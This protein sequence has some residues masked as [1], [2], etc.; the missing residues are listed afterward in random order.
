[1]KPRTLLTTAALIAAALFILDVPAAN[2]G[3]QTWN[4]SG[5]NWNNAANWDASDGASEAAVPTSADLAVLPTNSSTPYTVYMDAN[6]GQCISLNI[7]VDATLSI[8]D[9]K[10]LEVYGDNVTSYVDG[11]ILL[12]YDVS[13][14]DFKGTHIV[15]YTGTRGT[16][17]GDHNDAQITIAE[18]EM[19]TSQVNITGS[20]A[21]TGAGNFTNAWLVGADNASETLSLEIT[22]TLDDTAGERWQA[23]GGTLDFTAAIGTLGPLEGDLVISSGVI[24][25]NKALITTGALE[26]TDGTLAMYADVTVSSATISGT[27]TVTTGAYTLTITGASG[28]TIDADGVLNVND[29][30]TV[31]LSGGGTPSIDGTINLLYTSSGS[32]LA[33]TTSDHT[34]SYDSSA[35]SIVGANVA[36]QITL[37]SN[38]LDLISYITIRGALEITDEAGSPTGTTF[39]NSGL[40]HANVSGTLLLDI[41]GT[42]DDGNVIVDTDDDRWQASTNA[43][44]KLEF[45]STIGTLSELEGDFVLSLGEIEINHALTTV[46]L[47]EISGDG[48]LDVNATTYMGQDFEQGVKLAR[49]MSATGGTLDVASSMTFTHY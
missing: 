41:R 5:S 22:G 38:N 35:G 12:P 37:G 31:V 34:L 45:A 43:S 33:F 15:S 6:P 47:L 27:G 32:T 36:C 14:L 49:S 16:I 17:D 10:T 1:M 18:D 26:V 25:V 48:T 8:N 40:V 29:G 30:G 4:F 3:T 23:A 24:L 39:T 44:A 28:L 46:G 19:L 7:H 13:E 2:A 21:I 20:L 42:L 9:D 11:F